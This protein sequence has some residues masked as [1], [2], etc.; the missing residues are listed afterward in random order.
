MERSVV[1]R[2]DPRSQTILKEVPVDFELYVSR[3]P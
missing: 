3:I 2:R 1:E